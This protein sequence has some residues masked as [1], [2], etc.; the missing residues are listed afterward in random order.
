MKN[1]N[2]RNLMSR[3]LSM[4]LAKNGLDANLVIDATGNA[5]LNVRG[6]R[7]AATSPPC[8]Y[9]LTQRQLEILVNSE[10][11][12]T[13]ARLKKA[14][15]EIN[16]IIAKDFF[17]PQNYTVAFNTGLSRSGGRN[18]F[19]PVNMGWNGVEDKM[20]KS[21]Y[22]PYRRMTQRP[23]GSLKPGEAGAMRQLPNGMYVP[24]AGYVWKGNGQQVQQQKQ[25]NQP[26]ITTEL[27]PIA[28]PRPEGKAVPLDS[29][30]VTA[31]NDTFPMLKDVLESHGIVIKEGKDEKGQP[32]KQLIVMAKD[33]K[34]NIIYT[35]SEEQ[36]AR[37]TAD[38]WRSKGEGSLESRLAIINSKIALDFKEPITR[39]MLNTKDY[40]NLSYKEGRREI[41]EARYIAYE[42]MQ[43]LKQS[44]REER[45]RIFM[46]PAAIDGRDISSILKDKA[47][48]NDGSHGRQLVV[49]EIRVDKNLTAVGQEKS[50]GRKDAYTMSAQIDGQW[51]TIDI[52]RKD[53][54]KFMELDP[55]HRL[56]MFAEKFDVAIDKG[57]DNSWEIIKGYNGVRTAQDYRIAETL[58]ATAN[59][60]ILHNLRKGTY[61]DIKGGRE[62]NV[63]DIRVWNLDDPRFSQKERED[64][65]KL[66]GKPLN[67]KNVHHIIT[68]NIDGKTVVH[69]MTQ[70]QFDR[71]MK[72]DDTQRLKIADRIFD[73]FKIKTRP[74][75]KTNTGRAIL[76]ILGGVAGAT[77]AVLTAK[78][79]IE[80]RPHHGYGPH[81][82]EITPLMAAQHSL[83][84]FENMTENIAAAAETV[85]NGL[86]K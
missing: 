36:Y 46:D 75:Y 71:F 13:G 24:T 85:T 70:K 86:H 57:Y 10:G 32:E 43:Q 65:L 84:V 39:D 79:A 12:G 59:T 8:S 38:G 40:V 77:V 56:R 62:K 26:A 25:G 3:D 20:G 34:V 48:Y 19:V 5:V 44:I 68:A 27:A 35:L 42:Q 1:R 6:D 9:K 73:E 18:I 69:E 61:A 80:H 81:R 55:S 72:V 67:D 64:V 28:A 66:L 82:E 31:G 53:Y 51:K 50:D 45:E 4:L 33:A 60:N 47:F 76:G 83:E 7:G 11:M 30:A 63:T 29:L 54:D 16:N 78:D 23:D 15:N 17:P 49:G 52:S 58:G 74:E 14:Y 21:P 41:N 37:L 22:A 2:S